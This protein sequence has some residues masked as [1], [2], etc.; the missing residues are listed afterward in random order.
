MSAVR[1]DE[2]VWWYDQE[3][4]PE[5]LNIKNNSITLSIS[6]SFFIQDICTLYKN[7]Q[8]IY[9]P[10]IYKQTYVNLYNSLNK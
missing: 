7:N 9:L 8:Y 5:E 4:Y 2:N 6:G 10:F 3:W 1:I